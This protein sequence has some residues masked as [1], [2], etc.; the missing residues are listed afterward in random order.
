M[1]F[2]LHQA[3]QTRL[4]GLL[5]HVVR[6]TVKSLA[7]AEVAESEAAKKRKTIKEAELAAVLQSSKHS[8][9][10]VSKTAGGADRGGSPRDGVNQRYAAVET[11]RPSRE[12]IHTNIAK[13]LAAL[14]VLNALD[15]HPEGGNGFVIPVE[16]DTCK[17]KTFVL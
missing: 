11:V 13:I 16:H 5:S 4:T 9:A 12:E 8:K 14:S 15:I 7:T 17:G 10:M 3:E 2:Y 6:Q 1:C